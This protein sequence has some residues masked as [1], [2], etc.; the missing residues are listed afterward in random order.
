[1]EKVISI[2]GAI[3]VKENSPSGIKKATIELLNNIFHENDLKEEKIINIIF[4]VTD[5]LDVI[6]PATIAR[7]DLN[8]KN[9]PLICMQ[10]M[11]VNNGLKKCIRVMLQAYSTIE[12]ENVKHVYLEDAAN[13][14]PDLSDV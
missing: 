13:L 2:R 3:T 9:T 4:T 12:K 7:E 11:K 1:M 8:I 5:D 10:E 14:R 6:N